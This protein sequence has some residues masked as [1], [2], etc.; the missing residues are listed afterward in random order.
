MRRF[1]FG[2]F[3]TILGYLIGAF[4]GGFAVSMLSSNRHDLSV[5][6]AMTGAFVIGPL[7][8]LVGL[9]VGVL[10]GAPRKNGRDV[11]R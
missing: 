10:R 5:E 2:L 6:A 1:A 3:G 11:L 4:G 7:G 9:V 8:A